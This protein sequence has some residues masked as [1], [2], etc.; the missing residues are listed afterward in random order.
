MSAETIPTRQA[1]QQ[2][3]KEWIN[4][5]RSVLIGDYVPRN[6]SAIAEDSAGALGN[7]T[8]PF[9][10]YHVAVGENGPGDLDFIYD[11]A[12]T[13]EAPEGWMLCDGRV[14]NQTNYD[15]EHGSGA[16]AA[17][18]VSSSLVNKYLPNFNGKYMRSDSGA[19]TQ[20]GS[21]P[22]TSEGNAGNTINLQ[23]NHG[24]SVTTGGNSSTVTI[25]IPYA[26]DYGP[27]PQNGHTHTVDIPNDLSAA[28]DIRPESLACKV[29][30][31]II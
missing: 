7:S 15:T 19:A 3:K 8:Y 11:Y 25:T 31:R 6:S 5:I 10:D 28:Q 27:Y 1:P 16:W 24:G 12:G 20:A 21:S 30:M 4:F 23:H 26:S 13:V 9:K 17:Y 18:I 14:I 2:L 22:I 29:F